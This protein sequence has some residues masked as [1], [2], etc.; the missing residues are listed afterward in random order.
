M[1]G[2]D[3]SS[4]GMRI[5]CRRWSQRR[6]HHAAVFTRGGDGAGDSGDG[7]VSDS[8]DMLKSA[9]LG[10]G[11]S[12]PHGD[13]RLGRH[14]GCLLRFLLVQMGLTDSDAILGD[15][16][17]GRRPGF[18]RKIINSVLDTF[19][20]RIFFSV[21]ACSIECLFKILNWL[22]SVVFVLLIFLTSSSLTLEEMQSQ[23]QTVAVY[24]VSA[25]KYW[26]L[27]NLNLPGE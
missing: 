3:Y 25:S 2:K 22:F 4:C 7:E 8:R 5:D 11:F 15:K 10:E 21:K 6:L 17:H 19:R 20:L 1:F 9:G 13:W 14:Q 18:G 27:P 16:K 12:Q 23:V 24:H 26:C